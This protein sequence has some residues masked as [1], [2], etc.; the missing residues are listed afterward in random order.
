M[1]RA[2]TRKQKR[3]VNKR[4]TKEQ[5]DALQSDINKEFIKQE[6]DT[7]VTFF[8]N[9]FSECIK[10]AFVKNNISLTKAN[11]ILDD[12]ALI[13]NRKVEE[14]RNAKKKLLK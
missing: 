13:M 4:F 12:V 9:F 1:G 10:E 8:Q 6:V 2:E 11:I 3:A 5:F 14:K 7:Q